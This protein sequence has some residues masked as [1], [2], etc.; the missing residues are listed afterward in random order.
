M[1]DY[2]HSAISNSPSGMYKTTDSVL[3]VSFCPKRNVREADTSADLIPLVSLHLFDFC[4]GFFFQSSPLWFAHRYNSTTVM[5]RNRRTFLHFIS[6]FIIQYVSILTPVYTVSRTVM[7]RSLINIIPIWLS[8]LV[9]RPLVNTVPAVT[10]KLTDP[11]VLPECGDLYIRF[12]LPVLDLTKSGES[13]HI[14]VYLE[15]FKRVHSKLHEIRSTY[16][17]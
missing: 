11:S 12:I 17:H 5:F 4:D 9:E 15:C 7:G 8:I 16:T 6:F 10:P 1:G 3:G 13:C 2:L 14:T